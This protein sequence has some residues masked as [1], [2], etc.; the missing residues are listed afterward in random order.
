VV[1]GDCYSQPATNQYCYDFFSPVQCRKSDTDMTGVQQSTSEF[2]L[3][4]R[5]A[6]PGAL[7]L[8]VTR[9]QLDN[10][11]VVRFVGVRDIQEML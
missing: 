6:F 2:G 3:L 1:R 4:A 7:F 5:L 11:K 10:A 9:R 8:R